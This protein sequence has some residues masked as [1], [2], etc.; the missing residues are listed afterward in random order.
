MRA[1]EFVSAGVNEAAAKPKTP[2]QQRIDVLKAN[3]QRAKSAERRERLRQQVN[4][5]HEQMLRARREL[6]KPAKP[7]QIGTALSIS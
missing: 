3:T 2:E 7:N 4:K 6:A 5:G 1:Y